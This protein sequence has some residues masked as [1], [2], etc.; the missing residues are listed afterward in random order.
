VDT[1]IIDSDEEGDGSHTETDTVE[2]ERAV[3]R[4]SLTLSPDDVQAFLDLVN[5]VGPTP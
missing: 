5:Q 3:A 4:G 1:V 2:M